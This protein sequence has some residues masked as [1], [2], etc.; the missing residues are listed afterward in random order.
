VTLQTRAAEN[1]RACRWGYE[2]TVKRA[3]TVSEDPPMAR[4]EFY[5]YFHKCSADIESRDHH[6]G[7][8]K[9]YETKK[10]SWSFFYRDENN[11]CYI[12]LFTDSYSFTTVG[13]LTLFGKTTTY[14]YL[15]AGFILMW[16]YLLILFSVRNHAICYCNKKSKNDISYF[17]DTKLNINILNDNDRSIDLLRDF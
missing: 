2:R 14:A 12:L 10:Q 16:N 11:L 3:Q 6:R 4:A 9:Y 17:V 8:Q 1:F 15:W 7:E 5:M 13:K